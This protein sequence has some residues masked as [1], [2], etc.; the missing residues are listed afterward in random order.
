MIG[1]LDEE[2][3]RFVF[4][5]LGW[6]EEDRG[7]TSLA[8]AHEARQITHVALK[9]ESCQLPAVSRSNNPR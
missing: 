3:F 1:K 8:T 4:S 5:G 9:A 2:N 6:F 7:L